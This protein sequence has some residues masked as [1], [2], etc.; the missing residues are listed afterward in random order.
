MIRSLLSLGPSALLLALSLTLP[1]CVVEHDTHYVHDNDPTPYPTPGTGTGTTPATTVPMLVEVDTGQVLNAT[2]GDGVGVF[3]EYAAGGKWHVWWTCDSNRT[4]LTCPFDII[5]RAA[6]ITNLDKKG[7]AD[8]SVTLKGTTELQAQTQTDTNI[9][10]IT[11]TTEPGAAITVD[12]IVDNIPQDGS[13]LFFVQDGKVR[14]GFAGSV[15][16]PLDLQGKT[17]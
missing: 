14:G 3:I 8:G 9:D 16:N 11:F 5:V 17:P 15:S 6:S 2:G 13:Y 7:V 12:A 4:N 10:S 1:A